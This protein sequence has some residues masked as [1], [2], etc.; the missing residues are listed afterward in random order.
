MGELVAAARGEFLR[1]GIF[2]SITNRSLLRGL[3]ALGNANQWK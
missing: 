3:I 2:C 1:L